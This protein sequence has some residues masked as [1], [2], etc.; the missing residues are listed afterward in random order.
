MCYAK[1]ISIV[2]IKDNMVHEIRF[3]KMQ[4][5]GND[6]IVLE[7]PHYPELNWSLL[8]TKLCDR[9]FGIGSDGI[10]LLSRP[11]SADLRMIMLNPDGTYD[12]CGNGLRCS[13][14][15]ALE[16][17][18]LPMN[19]EKDRYISIATKAGVRQAIIHERDVTVGMSVPNFHPKAIPALSSEELLDYTLE[20]PDSGVR[21]TISALSTGS[22]HAITFTDC[23]PDDDTFQ[24]I[25]SQVENHPLFPERISLMWVKL[26]DCN[27]VG[28]RI[29]ERGAGETLGCGTG[30]CAVAAELFRKNPD[31]DEVRV[32]S[33]G[34]D[35]HVKHLVNGELMMRGP[36]EF[37][38]DGICHLELLSDGS[39][40]FT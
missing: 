18:M 15:Y 33:K 4:G 24:K 38:Y 40:S 12:F 1:G 8:A 36:A 10:L 27:H 17:G 19:D 16:R 3:T 35:L 32:S 5:V 14:R 22:A 25:S 23:L 21:L 29:W 2:T 9:R 20:L 34:G 31:C 13:A 30:A 28:I 37:V 7:E 6:F 26:Q 11:E 39:V